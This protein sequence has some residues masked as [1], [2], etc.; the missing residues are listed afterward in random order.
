MVTRI[1][2]RL[3]V[4]AGSFRMSQLVMDVV[5]LGLV[6]LGVALERRRMRPC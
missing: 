4:I 5:F 3:P 6:A 2:D 1:A